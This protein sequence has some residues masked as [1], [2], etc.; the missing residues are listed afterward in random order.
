MLTGTSRLEILTYVG[1]V[2]QQ[3]WKWRNKVKFKGGMPD[4][5]V[6]LG[7]IKSICFEFLEGR[8]RPSIQDTPPPADQQIETLAN[9]EFIIF[10]D[11]SWNEGQS[12]LAVV[13]INLVD[14][15]WFYKVENLTADSAMEAETLAV[16]M[17]LSLIAENSWRKVHVLSDCRNVLRACSLKKCHL[18]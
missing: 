3:I 13:V 2:F 1:C 8:S 15:S 17:A 9:A 18:D 11:A 12:G 7:T 4:I 6:T 16:R 14:N 10:T 5:N